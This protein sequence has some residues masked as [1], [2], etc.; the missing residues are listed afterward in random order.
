MLLFCPPSIIPTSTKYVSL[1][2]NGWWLHTIVDYNTF[3][4]WTSLH[5]H[6]SRL[7][8]LNQKPNKRKVCCRQSQPKQ[9][10]FLSTVGHRWHA[11]G[12]SYLSSGN[13]LNKIENQQPRYKVDKKLSTQ[14]KFCIKV[15][16]I[17]ISMNRSIIIIITRSSSNGSSRA[18][19]MSSQYRALVT[20]SRH[21]HYGH[22]HRFDQQ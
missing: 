17:S 19:V 18:I 1:T 9:L 22:H 21:V 6:Q 14:N 16:F 10:R 20:G 11:T 4:Q 15:D 5:A 3:A 12:H 8:L 2:H 7:Y 13:S